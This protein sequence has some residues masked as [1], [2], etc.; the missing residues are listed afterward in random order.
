MALQDVHCST[1]G[2]EQ[3]SQ[4]FADGHATQA[5]P[6]TEYFVAAHAAHADKAMLATAGVSVF[7]GQL[8]QV[9]AVL[10]A[11]A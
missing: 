5:E 11:T 6:E 8:V 3:L 2:P 7:A 4:L 10:P 9:I 1:P